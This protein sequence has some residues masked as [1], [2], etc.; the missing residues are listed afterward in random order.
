MPEHGH[1]H[2]RTLA[3]RERVPDG[4]V[5]LAIGPG[6][7]ARG[8]TPYEALRIARRDVSASVPRDE[9]RWA[10]IDAPDGTRVSC[11]GVL[12][13]PGQRDEAYLL[14]IVNARGHA[15]RALPAPRGHTTRK[16][17]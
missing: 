4:R 1:T 14:G 2:R 13:L 3:M 5:V 11:T 7:W 15:V 8:R 6:C 16:A 10:I 9:Q 12:S 17:R